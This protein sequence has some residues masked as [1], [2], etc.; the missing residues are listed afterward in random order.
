[1]PNTVKIKKLDRRMNGYGVWTH[2]TMPSFSNRVDFIIN[3]VE[4]RRFLTR[5]FG[6]GIHEREAPDLMG[7]NMEIPKWGYDEWGSIYCRDEATTIVMT[8]AERF[9]KEYL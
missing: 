4:F 8:T 7:M 9:T 5:S 6:P 2:R 1:M 3:F